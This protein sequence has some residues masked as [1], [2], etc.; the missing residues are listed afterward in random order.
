MKRCKHLLPGG[1]TCGRLIGN[2]IHYFQ[3]T[4]FGAREQVTKE[5]PLFAGKHR[6]ERL[7]S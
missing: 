3:P 4:L 2:C 6:T 5:K 7:T 1:E